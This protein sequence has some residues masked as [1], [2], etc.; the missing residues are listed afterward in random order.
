MLLFLDDL[1]DLF[2]LLF[3]GIAAGWVVA[4]DLEKEN[5]LVLDGSQVF[6]HTLTVKAL[7][8]WVVVPEVGQL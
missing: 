2:P 3:G 8:G 5:L 4:A 1:Q 7:G 6:E